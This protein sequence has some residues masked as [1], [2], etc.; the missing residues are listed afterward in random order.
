MTKI[1]EKWYFSLI[2][3]PIIINIITVDLM[4][5]DFLNNWKLTLIGVLVILCSILLYELYNSKNLIKELSSKPKDRDRRIVKEL[6][7]ILDVQEFEKSI[8]SQNSWY[9]YTQK[10]IRKT[11]AFSE[12]SESLDYKTSD[13]DL[14]KL[15]ADLANSIF[16][17]NEYA[18][19]KL[20]SEGEFYKPAKENEHNLKITEEATPIMNNMTT[21]A[22]ENLQVL[23]KYLRKRDY[24]E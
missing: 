24:L 10:S 6:L 5:S 21:K 16:D 23:L 1:L 17:F 22:F 4:L 3:I 8:Y 19:T 11:I 14:N 2:L 9:G 18:S 7:E 15:I 20:Y 13:N 12:K